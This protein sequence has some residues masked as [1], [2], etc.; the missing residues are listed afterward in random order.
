MY[1]LH[2]TEN[3]RNMVWPGS[4]DEMEVFQNPPMV[5]YRRAPNLR[6]KL[7]RTRIPD[8]PRMRSKRLIPGMKPCGLNCPTRPYIEP[9]TIIQSSITSKKIEIN[10]TFNCKTRN[11]V[12]C[13][14]CER[15]REHI[16][17]IRNLHTNQHTGE[18]YYLHGHEL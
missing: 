9:G 12:Y 5:T 2:Y 6:D 11:V 14:K 18:H 1:L 13:I 10:G 15:V 7:I 3:W 8:P 16:G 17:Y 4:L